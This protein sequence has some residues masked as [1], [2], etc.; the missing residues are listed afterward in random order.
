MI[1][2]SLAG[3][4]TAFTLIVVIGA[5]NAFVLRQGLLREHVLWICLICATSDAILVTAGVAGMGTIVN[6]VPSALSV[7]TIAGAAFLIVYGALS[8]RRVFYPESLSAA[9]NGRHSLKGAVLTCLALTWLNPHVYLD[10]VGLIGA[11]STSFTGQ[12]AR[13]AFAGGAIAASYTFFFALGYGARLLAPIFAKPG[14]WA[15][16]DAFIA[17]IMWTIAAILIMG[18]PSIG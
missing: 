5:Q 17:L 14:A 3:F 12:D 18:H 4:A 6:A 7:L 13:A 8:L 15:A 2:A 16:L 1:A 9:K 10:T 11:I